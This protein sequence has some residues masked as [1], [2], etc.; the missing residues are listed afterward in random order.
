[1]AEPLD[2]SR[3][4]KMVDYAIDEM[5][6]A[7]EGSQQARRY[8]DS[9]QLTPAEIAVLKKR[10]Q[11]PLII[12]RIKRKIDAMV[13]LEQKGRVDPRALPR[14]PQDEDGADIATK[15]LVYVDDVSRF[16]QKRSQFCYNLAIEG[17]GGVEINVRKTA[18][19]YDPDIL[20]LRFEEIFFDPHS[21]ELDFSDAGY[22][23]IEKW[24]SLA[25]AKD[26]CRR[27]NQ[28]MDEAT[29][30]DML[31]HAMNNASSDTS[32]DRPTGASPRAWGDPKTQRVKLAYMYYEADGVW[33]LALFTGGGV[34]Y[35]EPS[36]FLDYSDDPNGV[37]ACGIEIQACYIDQENNR[38]GIVTDMI[39]M[40]DE[41]NKRRS[42]LLHMLNSRQTMGAQG[43][44]EDVAKMKRELA[45]PDGHIEYLQDPLATRPSFEIVPNGDQTQGQFE[46]LQ[47]SKSEIDMLGPNASLLGQLEGSQSGRAIIAQQQ[48]GM[49]ELA[50]FYDAMND[51]TLR[52]YRQM[53]NR[54]RQFWDGPR[55]IRVTD[56]EGSAQFVGINQPVPGMVNPDGTPAVENPVS[57]LDVD[58][59][60]DVSPEYASLQYEQFQ[61]LT[62]LAKS[63]MIQL[64][65]DVII[66]A[67]SLRNKAKLL[68][69]LKGG[70]DPQA[71]QMQQMQQQMQMQMA[72]LE[73]RLKAAEAGLKEA[74]TAKAQAEAQATMAGIGQPDAPQQPEPPDQKPMLDFE[75]KRAALAEQAREH[76]D[77]MRLEWSKHQAS[78]TLAREGAA[79]DEQV[80]AAQAAKLRRPEPKKTAARASA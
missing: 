15:A 57:Q 30:D 10:K 68:E 13:G 5:A 44:V 59:I 50:P 16:D 17:Y 35:D 65:P 55:W 79:A 78:T 49:A 77:K 36:P 22:K 62:E 7:R 29:L 27:F 53:W 69:K 3:L 20:R 64:P 63:G 43:A 75:A 52:V 8:Y 56:E 66:E 14:N 4:K 47:E 72:E 18:D 1:M 25:K 2:H 11:P 39:P 67:S 48:A 73:M 74:Q 21:R 37:P 23:G 40:Q 41:I 28:E 9:A 19:G 76:D 46:L 80:K 33:R 58:I 45:Q 71:A 26:F 38:Y 54:I 42:K 31:K 12:N 51:W 34:I 60:I 70:D 24:M 61:T 32:E 6:S